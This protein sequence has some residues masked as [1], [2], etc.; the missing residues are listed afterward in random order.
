MTPDASQICFGLS[1]ELNQ[2]SLSIFLQLLGR[3]EFA[4]EFTSRLS[5]DDVLELVDHVMKLLKSHLS[6]NEYHRLF[7]RDRN[8]H[9]HK[10]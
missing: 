10:E 2:E 3:S 8:H 1:D 5:S 9:E 4:E 7:L 6:E